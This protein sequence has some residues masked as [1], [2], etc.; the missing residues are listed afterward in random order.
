MS[1]ARSAFLEKLP[2]IDGVIDVQ[3]NFDGTITVTLEGYCDEIEVT[4]GFDLPRHDAPGAG[5]NSRA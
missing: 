4:T 3:D 5:S 2:S 1:A